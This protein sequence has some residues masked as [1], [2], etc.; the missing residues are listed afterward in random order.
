MSDL[1]AF[2]TDIRRRLGK[3]EQIKQAADWIGASI[4]W[5]LI[6]WMATSPMTTQGDSDADFCAAYLGWIDSNPWAAR[7]TGTETR[8]L[9]GQAPGRRASDAVSSSYG[10]REAVLLAALHS[11]SDCLHILRQMVGNGSNSVGT[12]RL[13]AEALDH[14]QRMIDDERLARQALE[15]LHGLGQRRANDRPQSTI[16]AEWPRA[17]EHVVADVRSLTNTVMSMQFH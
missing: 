8:A 5:D 16:D 14:A 12:L 2:P 15:D 3:M 11:Q 10:F 7:E 1:Q 13:A 6:D 4:E 9:S 17:I